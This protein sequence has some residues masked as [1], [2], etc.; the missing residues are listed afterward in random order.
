M[1]FKKYLFLSLVLFITLLNLFYN[2]IIAVL[3][4]SPWWS[5]LIFLIYIIPLI[6]VF[7]AWKDKRWSFWVLSAWLLIAFCIQFWNMISSYFDSQWTFLVGILDNFFVGATLILGLFIIKNFKTKMGKTRNLII[8][9][10]I[11]LLFFDL[12]LILNSVLK[13]LDARDADKD[14]AVTETGNEASVFNNDIYTE[15][16]NDNN[17]ID[18]Q[19]QLIGQSQA[20]IDDLIKKAL[21]IDSFAQDFV[22]LGQVVK[23]M[24]FK[25]VKD[26]EPFFMMRSEYTMNGKRFVHLFNIDGQNNYEYYPDDNIAFRVK[27][28]PD[29]W[30]ETNYNEAKNTFLANFG[31][32][33][34]IDE[35]TVGDK[36]CYL[37]LFDNEFMNCVWKEK[38][39]ALDAL[40]E[41]GDYMFFKNIEFNLSDDLFRL[42][43]GVEI[44][45]KQ[46]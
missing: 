13:G 6:F 28:G 24:S 36:D 21:T 25:F 17:S 29:E 30:N 45:D 5:Y 15:K 2:L 46:V 22:I 32:A 20:I 9:I 35:K 39:I 27:K 7:F 41:N 11:L 4:Q 34:V 42:P 12:V 16:E 26:G 31:G 37:L 10:L 19:S 14:Q 40:N 38:G 18:A 43:D 33:T 23:R 3:N 8:A 1:N 44:V